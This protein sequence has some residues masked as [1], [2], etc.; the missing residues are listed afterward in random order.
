MKRHDK[1][2]SA[3]RD[4]SAFERRSANAISIYSFFRHYHWKTRYFKNTIDLIFMT[5]KLQKKFIHCMTRSKMNQSSDYI[6]IFTKL[7]IIV[8]RNESRRRRA[9]K[10]MSI[11]KLLN[12]WRE[13]VASSSFSCVAQI[14]AYALKIQQCVLRSIKIFVSWANFSSEIKFFWNEKCA[15]TMTTTKRRQKEWISL[16]IEKTWQNYLRTSNEKKRI[17]AKKKKI[18][19]K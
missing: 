4:E 11:D 19:F 7:M 6:S 3:W 1:I 13:F 18:E 5:K 9:W 14:E 15:E 12:N 2:N 8:K 10:S 16:H 17:I